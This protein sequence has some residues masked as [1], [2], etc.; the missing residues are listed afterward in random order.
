LETRLSTGQQAN[1]GAGQDMTQISSVAN[2]GA[3]AGTGTGTGNWFTN[4]LS[5]VVGTVVGKVTGRKQ[6]DAAPAPVEEY[7]GEATDDDDDA[8]SVVSSA[9]GISVLDRARALNAKSAKPQS[10]PVGISM[11]TIEKYLKHSITS[12]SGAIIP[13][14]QPKTDNIQLLQALYS[15]CRLV[16]PTTKMPLKF[17]NATTVNTAISQQLYK[18][19]LPKPKAGRPIVVKS[20]VV[21]P[22]G[23]PGRKPGK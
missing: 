20:D 6:E 22:K 2:P 21:K 16:D 13:R 1:P 9:T 5:S 15:E 4:R 10:K 19:V 7:E 18:G 3:G 8:G 14:D 17:T 11:D 12:A 23:K